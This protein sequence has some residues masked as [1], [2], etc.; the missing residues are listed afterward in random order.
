MNQIYN[1]KVKQTGVKALFLLLT[2]WCLLLASCN[3]WLDVSPKSQIKE[4]DHFDRVG[5][6][7]DQ[8]TGIYTAMTSQ[9]M[10]GLNMGIGFVEVLSH[11]YD[12]DANGKWRYANE[13]NYTERNN[14]SIITA[15]WSKTY[16]C[17]ANANILI[18]N[19]EKADKN[20]FLDN[21]YHIYR[22]EAYGLRGFLHF[23][24]MRLFACAPS[25]D[26]NAK[27]VPYVTEYSTDIVGQKS[28]NETMQMV[29]N[30]LLIAHDEL[31]Y[32]TLNTYDYYGQKAYN[33]P[34]NKFNFFAC[35]TVLARAYLWVGDTQNALKYANEVIRWAEQPNSGFPWVHY[36]NMQQ[37]ARNELDA[38]FTSEHLFQLIIKDWEDTANYYFKKEGGSSSLSPTDATA[39]NIYEVDLGYGN[40]YRYLRG[41]E[42]DG[43]KRFMAKFWFIEGGRYNNMYPLVRR[44]EAYYIAAECQKNTNPAN[45]IAL[46]NTVR[47]NRNLSLFP[48]SDNLTPDQI[49]E[50]I[51]KEYRK[52]FVGESG[53][54]FYYYKRL[55][56][57]E[58]KGAS[59][60]PNKGIY[61]LPIP[62]NDKEFGGYT[63]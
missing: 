24:L 5:G 34:R 8:L 40:D 10:Y 22:G 53:Q 15:I 41:Y 45:A 51:F 56:A 42:Q 48:L 23:E 37:T 44:T 58:I 6:Y 38:A 9:D 1:N 17:I 36:T 47:E 11:S 50:E 31:A 7:K 28:V 21:D 55:N 3:D 63:N 2:P 32:D 39:Q 54:L 60:R 61:V 29:I 62:N 25:M 46:L 26:G 14:E 52:E 13:F 18:K 19:I 16:N 57:T 33:L 20:I 30:D 35:A 43:E 59:T 12:I 4:E 27:G 49:Q